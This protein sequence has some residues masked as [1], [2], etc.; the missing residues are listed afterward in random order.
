M[1]VLLAVTAG[2]HCRGKDNF[3]GE[4]KKN[5]APGHSLLLVVGEPSEN[6]KL[7]GCEA[8]SIYS[9]GSVIFTLFLKVYK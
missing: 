9:P 8:F 3:M 1:W 6:T 5:E 7:R 4:A 2:K